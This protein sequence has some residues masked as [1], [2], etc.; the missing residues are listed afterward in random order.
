MLPR[1]NNIRKIIQVLF[2]TYALTLVIFFSNIR[3]RALLITLLIPSAVVCLAFLWRCIKRRDF[4]RLSWGL[5]SVLVIIG[6]EFLPVPGTN[7]YTAAYNLHAEVLKT[8]GRLGDAVS[9]WQTSSACKQSYSV[10]AD[11]VL[12]G[13]YYYKMQNK[14]LGHAFALKI[15]DNSFAA[16]DKYALLG[17]FA[18][19]EGDVPTAI[20]HYRHSL[21]INSGQRKT[22][23]RLIA[24][25]RNRDQTEYLKERERLIT[26]AGYYGE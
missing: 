24:L 22:R 13:Y 17:D 2:W 18:R 19:H 20:M 6:I 12:A 5:A 1:Q 3:I 16:A 7:D 21:D 4:K 14:N 26:I 8:K 9:S 23:R 25:L 11:L 10:Y 15:P